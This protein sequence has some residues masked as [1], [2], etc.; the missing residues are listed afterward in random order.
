MYVEHQVLQIS[1]NGGQSIDC[2]LL[3]CNQVVKLNDADRDGL[4][5]LGLQHDLLQKRIL[6]DLVGDNHAEMSSFSDVPPVVAVQRGVCV[7]AQALR[8]RMV[9]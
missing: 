4:N 6:E 9:S 7:V 8:L 3:V 5:F 2:R 1:V